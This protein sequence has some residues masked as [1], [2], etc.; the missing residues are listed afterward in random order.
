M[1]FAYLAKRNLT[2]NSVGVVFAEY[3]IVVACVGIL[4]ATGLF[5]LGPQI[6][7]E[8]SDSRATLYSHSP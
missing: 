4:I 3:M 2:R 8:Y 1:S 6:L 5:T 7:A